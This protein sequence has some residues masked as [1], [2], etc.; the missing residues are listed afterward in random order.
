MSLYRY[1]RRR[2]PLRRHLDRG[3]NATGRLGGAVKFA[4]GKER[5][6]RGFL[7]L[8]LIVLYLQLKTSQ[9]SSLAQKRIS[10]MRDSTKKQVSLCKWCRTG[11]VPRRTGGSA[12][13]YCSQRCRHRHQRSKQIFADYCCELGVITIQDLHDPNS[14]ANTLRSDG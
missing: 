6:T 12:Q 7:L 2:S 1:I 4:D 14:A 9:Q 5:S 3:A 10:S 8:G 13:L 11:F